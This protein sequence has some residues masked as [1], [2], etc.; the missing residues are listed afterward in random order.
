MNNSF[1]IEI[2]VNWLTGGLFQ[3]FFIRLRKQAQESA[4]SFQFVP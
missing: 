4:G 1:P 3:K 2:L